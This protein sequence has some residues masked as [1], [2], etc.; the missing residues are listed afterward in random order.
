[1]KTI[2]A[3]VDFSPVSNDVIEHATALAAALHAALW[4]LHVAAPDPDFVGYDA[5]PDSVRRAVATEL[6]D[7]HRRL[8]ARS[9]ELRERGIDCTALLLQGSTADTI[10]REAERLHADLIVLG[11]RG[12][13]A[14]RRALLGSVSEHVL[15]HANRPLIIVPTPP[16][17]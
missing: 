16:L 15:H 9:A 4:L 12:H 13:G 6:H 5:G 10:V 14:L 3:A 17:A 2:L 7:V 8:Q 1:M 11:S